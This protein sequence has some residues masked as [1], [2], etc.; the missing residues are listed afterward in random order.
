MTLVWL[1]GFSAWLY[2]FA[3]LYNS[4]G[5]MLLWRGYLVHFA[6]L[7]GFP[8]LYDFSGVKR[9]FCVAK[10]FEEHYCKC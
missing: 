2:H 9:F 8:W 3:W 1:Y 10:W 5:Y 6:R 4:R 7:Y